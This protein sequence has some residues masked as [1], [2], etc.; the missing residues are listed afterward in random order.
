LTTDLGALKAAAID[1][2]DGFTIADY[3]LPDNPLVFVN[4]A[5]EIMTG[6]SLEDINGKNCRFLQAT[7]NGQ[8]DQL[9]ILRIA[10]KH[11]QRCTVTLRNYRKDG[12]LFSNQLSMS[13]IFDS[14]GQL[15]HYSGV[16]KDITEKIFLEKKL[17][18]NEERYIFAM[19][20]SGEGLWDW[21][22]R[23]DK[24]YFSLHWKSIM[25]HADSEVKDDFSEWQRRIHPDDK[26]VALSKLDEF[27]NSK[28]KEYRSEFR[29]QH[30][31]GRYI[32]IL[33]RA[34]AVENEAGETTRLVGTHVD[35]TERRKASEALRLAGSV[36][37]HAREGIV[38]T[39]AAGA[40][41]EVNST[42]TKITGY[43]SEDVLGR[44][45]RML[46]SPN[47]HSAVFYAAM[48]REIRDC[49]TWTGEIWNQRKDG[50]EYPATLTR[51]AVTNDA[52]EISHYVTHFS[53]ITQ[54]KAHQ[55]ELE[56]MAHYDALTG[57]PNRTLLTDRM[58]QAI[59]Q[60][61]R[62]DTSLAVAFLD[63]DDFKAVND[64]HGHT[65]GDELLI[66]VSQRM[67]EAL[68]EGDTLA[69][70]GGDEFIAVLADL[71]QVNDYQPVLERLLLAA[72]EPVTLG[73]LVLQISA[74]IGVTGYTKHDTDADMLLRHADQAMYCA[75]EAGK[76]QYHVFDTALDDAVNIRRESLSNIRAAL[77]RPDFVL[78]Y[79]PKVNMS[80]GEVVG[81]EAL[82]RWQHTA[83]GLVSPL[84]FLPIIEGHSLSLDIGE[85]VIDGAL[86]Q[87][88]HWK[89]IG[90]TL[91]ISVNI[92]AYQLQQV[93]FVTRL[94]ELLA[95]HP[96]VDPRNLELEV[97]E[98]SA[99][100]DINHVTA[101]MNACIDLGVHF[102][103]DDF[104]TGYSSLTYLR[105]LPTNLIK[106][107]Q[108]F[109]RDMLH[110]A[111]DLAIVEG[112]I[113][114][115]KAFQREVIA[116]G[117]ETIEHGTALL[118]MGCHLAQGYGIAKPMP[119]NDI[120]TWLNDWKPDDA[121]RT[122]DVK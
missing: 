39:N 5:F 77:N 63:L 57:L 103:L 34:F 73:E 72:S 35:M 122:V 16:Q 48:S 1:A 12:S 24:V 10:M 66:I 75:K 7:D 23:T 36:F 111:D 58:K 49:G 69:R 60:S 6:Y 43:S 120:P 9:E 45:P 115:A 40:I 8:E 19:K 56:Q 47:R 38:I 11:G 108:S 90:I 50:G 68:R 82:I 100:N 37:T 27:L 78:F 4:P 117:V 92:S 64:T 67:K 44:E 30:K 101:T 53:D 119:A 59:I 112:I 54:I 118:G 98:T 28:A 62:N 91:P 109:I 13:P 2:P 107:D 94:K 15:T 55:T 22:L 79:Q 42:F 26:D 87:I 83:R 33:S 116:E 86:R 20:A 65:V 52:G 46:Q 21:N 113:S 105:R 80:T 93:N 102:A 85:W 84:D 31:D 97:L 104:G 32:H 106:I 95:A 29:M 99:L 121:W 71:A 17:R 25:G 114:L 51:S 96:D 14:K 88:S 110:D 18:E 41:I 89:S 81:L 61:Q 74:S 70:I 3:S 76:N